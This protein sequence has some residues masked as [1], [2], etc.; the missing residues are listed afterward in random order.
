MGEMSGGSSGTGEDRY[1]YNCGELIQAGVNFCPECGA[2]QTE[3]PS[4]SVDDRADVMSDPGR[5]R[6]KEQAQREQSHKKER[7]AEGWTKSSGPNM[8]PDPDLP[9][10]WL[11]IKIRDPNIPYW[12]IYGGVVLVLLS[13]AEPALFFVGYLIVGIAVHIDGKYVRTVC[14]RWKPSKSYPVGAVLLM[15]VFVP[16]YLYRRSKYVESLD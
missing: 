15:I 6:E 5:R 3:S 10:T 2:D 16:L 13:A 4:E 9:V 14:K 1:C 7:P 12:S 11:G 8:E